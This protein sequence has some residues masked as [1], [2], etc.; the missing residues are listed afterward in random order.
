MNWEQILSAVSV[1]VGIA[2]VVVIVW[3][4]ILGIGKWAQIEI[5]FLRH[6]HSS[7]QKLLL[8]QQ[9]GSSLLLG[10]E[11]LIAADVIRTVV[12]P[13]LEEVAVLG[14]IV[15]IRTVISYFLHREMADDWGILH[16]IEQD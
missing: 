16:E 2:G 4:V 9:L 8:R 12:Q 15:A 1:G 14:G 11:F 7:R 13:S 3:G 10:L 5:Q 6:R